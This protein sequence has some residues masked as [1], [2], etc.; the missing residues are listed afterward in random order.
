M[1]ERG[2]GDDVIIRWL[3][4]WRVSVGM[5]RHRDGFC[6]AIERGLLNCQGEVGE[7]VITRLTNK[8][9][10]GLREEGKRAAR[11]GGRGIAIYAKQLPQK[12]FTWGL[13]SNSPARSQAIHPL[14]QVLEHQMET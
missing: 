6:G 9:E 11:R 3:S 1:H 13:E 10:K 8:R 12:A 4:D 7:G 2:Q 14:A 5:V